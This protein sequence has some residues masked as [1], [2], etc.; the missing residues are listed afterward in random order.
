MLKTALITL[1][2][3]ASGL[4][5][6]AAS[7]QTSGKKE[8]AAAPWELRLLEELPALGHRNWIVVADSAYPAQISP[9][10]EIVVSGED[11]LAVL[12]KVLKAIDGSRHV[13]PRVYLDKELSFLG[14]DLAPGIEALRA[15]LDGMLKGREVKPVLH[16][17]LIARL[18]QVAKTFRILM[19]KTNLALPYTSVFLELDCGYWPSESE[20]KLRQKM[21]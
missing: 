1:L 13:R 3:V 14:D 12:N 5:V 20:Q 2:I 21:R 15:R 18:D 6:G 17:E 9:G 8:S 7:A 10:M 19:I 11:H 4:G 16:E